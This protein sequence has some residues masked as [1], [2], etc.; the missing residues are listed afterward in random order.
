MNSVM[1]PI[2][3]PYIVP[4][5]SF[6]SATSLI[7][8]LFFL[9]ICASGFFLLRELKHKGEKEKAALF[10]AA[11]GALFALCLAGGGG[12][13]IYKQANLAVEYRRGHYQVLSG[14]L[15][16]MT[17]A[18]DDHRADEIKVGGRY[19]SYAEYASDGG[20][21]ETEIDGGEIHP[22]SWVRLYLIGYAIVRLD[23]RQ[24]ACPAA[25]LLKVWP[26]PFTAPS[27]SRSSSQS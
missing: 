13:L 2:Y 27:A 11:V 17:P 5:F 10:M 20:Y 21:H 14:C 6:E 9:F 26:A 16:A 15:E 4:P 25:P 1:S 24:H 3:T 22:D 18:K 8:S 12:L 7:F 23:V 19:L